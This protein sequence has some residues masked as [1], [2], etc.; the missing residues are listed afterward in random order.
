[1][2]KYFTNHAIPSRNN[3]VKV[4][5]FKENFRVAQ[6]QYMWNPFPYKA[7]LFI[8]L[9]IKYTKVTLP[10][11][12]SFCLKYMLKDKLTPG[13]LKLKVYILQGTYIY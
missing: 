5:K 9:T 7:E 13:S 12:I 2:G 8:Y 11:I 10:P 3:I 4:V 1:M 6:G